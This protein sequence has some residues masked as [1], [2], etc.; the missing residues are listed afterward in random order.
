MHPAFDTQRDSTDHL[1]R[2]SALA[3][4]VFGEEERRPEN[5]L[6][7]AFHHTPAWSVQ[8]L[9]CPRE[10]RSRRLTTRRDLATEYRCESPPG[11]LTIPDK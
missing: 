5:R 4:S 9:R 6:K 10:G 7:L 3:E 2:L 11:I 8:K 1:G